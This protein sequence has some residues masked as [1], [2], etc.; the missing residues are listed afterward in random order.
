MKIVFGLS[1]I[2]L[3]QAQLSNMTPDS[4]C[5]FDQVAV[6]SVVST[7][8]D[9]TMQNCLDWCQKTDMDQDDLYPAGT[10]MCCDFE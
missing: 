4:Y 3:V 2:L 7:S 6:D 8:S 10:D 1:S 5:D 9:Y